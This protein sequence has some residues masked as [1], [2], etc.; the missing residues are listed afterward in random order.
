LTAEDIIQEAIRWGKEGIWF[1]ATRNPMYSKIA[2]REY[3]LAEK[4]I[5]LRSPD[6]KK[7][8]LRLNGWGFTV[9]LIKWTK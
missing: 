8:I 7:D 5:L 9:C 6:K 4:K 3:F 2:G 1:S